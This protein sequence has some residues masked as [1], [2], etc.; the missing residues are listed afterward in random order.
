MMEELFFTE[1]NTAVSESKS[2]K[3]KKKNEERVKEIC[4]KGVNHSRKWLPNI[5][6]RYTRE[7][8]IRVDSAKRKYRKSCSSDSFRLIDWRLIV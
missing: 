5:E 8:V 7:F 2:K 3:K 1:F 4:R 6:Y